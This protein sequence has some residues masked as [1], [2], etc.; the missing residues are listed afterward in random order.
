MEQD[1]GSSPVRYALGGGPP[2]DFQHNIHPYAA[3]IK[4]GTE[5]NADR[6][7]KKRKNRRSYVNSCGPVDSKL[8]HPEGFE[9]P[10]F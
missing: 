5:E 9:P 4:P 3:E 8:V 10:T 6:Q 2:A 1:S 7:N